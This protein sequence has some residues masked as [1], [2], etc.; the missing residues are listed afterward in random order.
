ML[1]LSISKKE[2]VKIGDAV[3]YV[4]QIKNKQVQISIDAPRDVPINR[5]KIEEPTK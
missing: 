1:T 2:A 3:I 4:K 5:V